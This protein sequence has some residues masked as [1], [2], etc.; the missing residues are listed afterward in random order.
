MTFLQGDDK[1][2]QFSISPTHCNERVAQEAVIKEASSDRKQGHTGRG[3]TC[4]R[5]N[6][7]HKVCRAAHR[8]I[9]AESDSKATT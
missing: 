8:T 1:L 9:A 2:N 7:L 3:F 5:D 6:T 4:T